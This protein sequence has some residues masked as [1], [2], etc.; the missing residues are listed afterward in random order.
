MRYLLYPLIAANVLLCWA[1]VYIAIED[2]S[3]RFAVNGIVN[4]WAAWFA[5]YAGR[6][7]GWL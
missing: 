3:L 1:C 4:F 7:A 6:K 2:W 5:H